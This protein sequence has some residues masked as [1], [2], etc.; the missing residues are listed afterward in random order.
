MAF[1]TGTAQREIDRSAVEPF[2]SLPPRPVTSKLGT[3]TKV[4]QL[5]SLQ[6]LTERL[7][8]VLDDVLSTPQKQD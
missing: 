3:D 2:L 1:L 8:V 5:H 7:V 6:D 4:Y